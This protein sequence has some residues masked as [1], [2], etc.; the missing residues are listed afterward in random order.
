MKIFKCI[1]WE[2][3]YDYPCPTENYLEAISTTTAAFDDIEGSSDTFYSEKIEPESTTTT[4]MESSIAIFITSKMT[5]TKS[6]IKT[7]TA[8]IESTETPTWSFAQTTEETTMTQS[9][10]TTQKFSTKIDQSA[11]QNFDF[12]PSVVITI[13]L[14]IAFFLLLGIIYKKWT[15]PRRYQIKKETENESEIFEL[16]PR[17]NSMPRATRDEIVNDSRIFP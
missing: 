12:M 9:S 1:Q 8:S 13:M 7:T 15:K 16:I 17:E 14:N 4:E 3:F 6:M 10:R 2:V 11:A 5:R